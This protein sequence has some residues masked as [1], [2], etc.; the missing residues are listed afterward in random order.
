MGK[1]I[2]RATFEELHIMLSLSPWTVIEAA[3]CDIAN[4]VVELRLS[5]PRFPERIDPGERLAAVDRA[6][7]EVLVSKE[8]P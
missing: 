7:Y 1:V 2:Y 8:R 5:D 4:D 6:G 3:Q